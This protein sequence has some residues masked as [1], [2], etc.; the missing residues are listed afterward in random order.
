MS[1]S[2]LPSEVLRFVTRVLDDIYERIDDLISSVTKLKEA[3]NK[4]E[5]KVR[6]SSI[7]IINKLDTIQ[8]INRSLRMKVTDNLTQLGN[9]I[10]NEFKS[11]LTMV[12]KDN[13]EK[14]LK[15]ISEVVKLV[16]STSWF[17]QISSLTNE[18][19]RIL[20]EIP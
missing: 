20:K 2:R 19:A 18:V 7:E 14:T 8:G 10:V 9:N 16:N 3:L 5:E 1:E 17:L 6:D 13:L 11:T 12:T 15:D 4:L